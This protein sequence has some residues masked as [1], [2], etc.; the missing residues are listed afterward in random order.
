MT[1]KWW[2]ARGRHAENVSVL[3]ISRGRE[4]PPHPPLRTPLRKNCWTYRSMPFGMESLLTWSYQMAHTSSFQLLWFCRY[5]ALII[6]VTAGRTDIDDSNRGNQPSVAFP[7]KSVTFIMDL[8][9]M[10]QCWHTRGR[11]YSDRRELDCRNRINLYYK[12]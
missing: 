10:G 5:Q 11:P 9:V 1:D 7:L 8:P 6:T 2:P 12:T 3:P 4:I